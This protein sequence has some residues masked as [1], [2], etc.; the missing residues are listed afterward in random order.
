MRIILLALVSF[1]PFASQVIG[2]VDVR[3]KQMMP[4]VNNEIYA[5]LSPSDG[6]A[7]YICVSL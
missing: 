4:R 3:T 2:E 7:Q 5:V 1:S 6:E